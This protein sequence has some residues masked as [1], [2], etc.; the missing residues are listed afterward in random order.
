MLQL[1]KEMNGT[2]SKQDVL[3]E[4][5]QQFS[6]EKF[7]PYPDSSFLY[8]QMLKTKA[9]RTGPQQKGRTSAKDKMNDL[10]RQVAELQQQKQ[11][12]TEQNNNLECRQGPLIVLVAQ[13]MLLLTY[14]HLYSPRHHVLEPRADSLRRVL[15]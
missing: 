6:L 8:S 9:Q 5:M 12:L 4:T 1:V 2:G 7:H 3:L 13:P 10:E 14:P 15:L 11:Q